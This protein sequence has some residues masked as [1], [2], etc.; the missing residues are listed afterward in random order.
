MN[1]IHML[2]EFSKC[3]VQDYYKVLSYK[4][5]STKTAIEVVEEDASKEI[6]K[7]Y[8]RL[9]KITIKTRKK[10]PQ[11]PP[12]AKNLFLGVFDT[13]VLAYPQLEK[14]ELQDLEKAIEPVSNYFNSISSSFLKQPFVPIDFMNNL[15]QLELFGLRS[16][17]LLNGRE[18]D[19]IGNC[20]F[21]EVIANATSATPSLLHN[22]HLGIQILLNNG[23][24][25][26]QKKYLPQLINGS[27]L[28]AFCVAE[29]DAKDL[30]LLNTTA[31]YSQEHNAW[32]LNGRKTAVINGSIADLYI[33][34]ALTSIIGKSGLREPQLTVLLVDKNCGGITFNKKHTLGL[35]ATDVADVTFD[36][37]IV[38]TENVIGIPKG[39][40]SVV[41]SIL[42]EYRLSSGPACTTLIRKM[43]NNLVDH[44]KG[45][46]MGTISIAEADYVRQAIAEMTISLYALESVTYLTAGLLDFYEN[47]DCLLESTI[48]KVFSAEEACKSA[49][50][51]M[52]L[53]GSPAY[54]KE[55]W[56]NILFRDALSYR[57]LHESSENLKLGIALLGMQHT[58]QSIQ[59]QI[60]KIR[61]PLFHAKY[62]FK[63]MWTHR[64]QGVD[65][66]DLK[67]R[68]GDYVHP[69][70]Q[71]PAECLEYTVLRL[72]YATE[73]L[74]A[75][76]GPEIVNQHMELGKL[77][78][79][80]IDIYAMA[81]CLA[82]ASRSYCIGLEN[83]NYE[84][85]IA[86][87][88]CTHAKLR[89]KEK[90]KNLV[91]GPYASGYESYRSIAKRV[92]KYGQY[93][94][95]HPLSRNY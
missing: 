38:P 77:A 68:L 43:I 44:C 66:P 3:N 89:V 64:K 93:F 29:N 49:I 74:L 53:L 72:Q 15:K 14:E 8:E 2:K 31:K 46:N 87:T 57:H 17:Q 52:D 58:G 26:Q 94:P 39:G 62:I 41:S 95:V 21:N 92:F 88:Y 20:K 34:I 36:N 40:D 33:V 73:I 7:Q 42:T 54:M 13:D 63:R 83:A 16:S 5:Y 81:A 27:V 60:T 56:C 91:E 23:N 75:R 61:N 59:G 55:H 19:V 70:L 37:I 11:K 79:C 9:S 4:F 10:S 80:V 84:M 78:E 1:R 51:C 24:E 67:L 90:I 22:E 86:A 32:I 18:L 12:F 35:E 28:S 85:V 71:E 47:Q 82:R 45:V 65:N 76:F 48:V 30:S 69:S 25:D 6:T 50:K